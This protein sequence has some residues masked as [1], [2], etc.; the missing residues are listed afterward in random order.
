MKK[1]AIII[2]AGPAGL[3]AAYELL[4][5]TDI[6]PVIIEKD[7][8][9][10]GISKTVV[11][12]GNRMDFGPHRF[13]S[14]SDRVMKWW[15]EIMPLH[16]QQEDLTISYQNKSRSVDTGT[17]AT[18]SLILSGLFDFKLIDKEALEEE[19]LQTE[20]VREEE[21]VPAGST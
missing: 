18:V 11:Y 14:K 15:T 10:G 12:K 7:A 16:A 2:G 4:K 5:R 1:K 9:V 21:L 13:F 6:T 20:T 8:S 3:T 17:F 19:H